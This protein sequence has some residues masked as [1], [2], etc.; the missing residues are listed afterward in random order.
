MQ[1]PKF[2]TVNRQLSRTL[3]AALVIA[4]LGACRDVAPAFGNNPAASRANADG[5]FGGIAQRFTNVQRSPKFT[6]ARAKLG[7][8]ALI[9]SVIYNDTSVW[10]AFGSDSTRLITI[11]GEFE[12]N[13]YL[14]TARPWPATPP[15]EPGDSRHYIR[16]KMVGENQYEWI[17]NVDI[18]AGSIKPDEFANVLSKFLLSSENRSSAELRADYRTSFPR[19]TAALGRLFSLDTISVARDAEG[20]TFVQ[21]GIRLTPD[22]IR[23]IMPDFAKYLDKYVTPAQYKALVTDKR[24]GR[25]VELFG[26]DNYMILKLRTKNGHLVPLNG[27]LRPLPSEF[28]LTSDFTTKILFFTVGYKKLISDVTSIDSDRERGW[29]FRF[30]REPHWR[31]PSAVSCLIHSPL[32]RPFPGSGAMVRL[33]LREN[34]GSQTIIARRTSTVVQ[35]SAI[36]RFIGK[37][38][39][40]AMGDFVGKSESEEN[41]FS[42]EVFNALRLDIRAVL[43]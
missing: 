1:P 18:A 17:T 31:L 11:D 12:S 14:F 3:A 9:P 33:V 15:N 6:V 21:M 25:W 23:A 32:K 13:R 7:K 35:E 4:S 34:P 40:T 5:L 36:L 19:T 26:D 41:R 42:A 29:L 39:A 24:G 20:A 37:L 30:T 2:R 28:Q 8:N 22:G 27:P 16:L 38:G 10:T 43:Q